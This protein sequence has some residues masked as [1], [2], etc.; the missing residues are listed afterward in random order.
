MFGLCGVPNTN[1][2]LFISLGRFLGYF[3]PKN[4]N[5][6]KNRPKIA[7]AKHKNCSNKMKSSK[8]A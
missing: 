2:G 1:F 8:N 7:L 4:R 3:C 6:K 5:N